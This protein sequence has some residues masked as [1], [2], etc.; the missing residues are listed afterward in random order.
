MSIGK[1]REILGQFRFVGIPE[2]LSEAECVQAFAPTRSGPTNVNTK[3]GRTASFPSG[4][5][6][7]VI[8]TEDLDH[9]LQIKAET[10]MIDA[11]HD[12]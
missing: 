3:K 7:T 4:A 11:P 12:R 9:L 6:L 1:S 10:R 8:D 5:A 2:A